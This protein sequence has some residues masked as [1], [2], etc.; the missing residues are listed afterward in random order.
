MNYHLCF[1]VVQKFNSDWWIGRLVKEGADV[2]F[3]P[4]PSKLDSLRQQQN[5]AGKTLKL[6]ARQGRFAPPA[7][8]AS[9][10]DYHNMPYL[11]CLASSGLTLLVCVGLCVVSK[12]V[13]IE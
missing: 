3:I 7:R 12:L 13:C 5:Q 6:Y 9:Y 8:C 2:G 4:S 1:C 10:L 11:S